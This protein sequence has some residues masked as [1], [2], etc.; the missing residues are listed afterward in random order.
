MNPLEADP[1]ALE[2]FTKSW[3]PPCLR[4]PVAARDID[5]L[6]KFVGEIDRLLSRAGAAPSALLVR[7]PER[8]PRP[9][10][11]CALDLPVWQTE[12]S[13][14]LHWNP[15]VWVDVDYTRYRDAYCTAFPELDLSGYVVDHVTNRRR[16]RKIGWRYVRLC[17][18]TN[19]V[20]VSS[21]QGSERLAVEFANSASGS[22]MRWG[23]IRYAD[24]AD[25]AKM[26]GFEIGGVPLNGLRD[27]LPL[28][29]P[30]AGSKYRGPCRC[31]RVPD[32]IAG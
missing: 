24:V 13:A 8:T 29:E 9:E 32:P 15:Q 14:T 31:D 30:R 10:E 4:V 5:A 22:R 20:N 23:Q 1:V 7:M 21:G 11:H 25:L 12:A 2:R 18:V 19:A 17:H 28:F 16:A 27:V 6:T 3:M 26:L